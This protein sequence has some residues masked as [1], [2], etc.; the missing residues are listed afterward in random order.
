VTLFYEGAVYQ[1]VEFTAAAD[2][3]LALYVEFILGDAGTWTIHAAVDGTACAAEVTIFILGDIAGHPFKADV[4]WL[5]QS[6]ITTGCTPRTFC[7]DTPVTREQMASFLVRALAF[8]PTLTDF[9][10]DDEGSVHED[11]INR[12]AASRV[13]TGCTATLF[14]P[15]DPVTRE[16]M[17][18]FLVR[19]LSPP[20]TTT[21]FFTDDAASVHQSDI[22]R[23]AASGITTGCTATLFCPGALVTRGQMSAFL[24]RGLE[25]G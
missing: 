3:S 7:P 16:Q 9:Y 24:H 2:G 19:G 25:P 13:T 17:A 4:T 5:R 6:G 15:T 11:D 14:C 23:L 8:P 20:D 21:D 10:T 18:S 12:L 22:N 1:T